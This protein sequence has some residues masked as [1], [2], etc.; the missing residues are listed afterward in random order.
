MVTRSKDYYFNLFNSEL[1]I[2]QAILDSTNSFWEDDVQPRIT[3]LASILRLFER[4]DSTSSFS[5]WLN[6]KHRLDDLVNLYNRKRLV[7]T[8]EETKHDWILGLD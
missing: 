8:T 3:L 4:S 5:R 1:S 2:T 6:C 7:W